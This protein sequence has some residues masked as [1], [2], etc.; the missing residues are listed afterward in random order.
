LWKLTP[1]RQVPSVI[2]V[3]RRNH[4]NVRRTHKRQ[5]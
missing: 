4:Q 3:E 2:D 1:K 5:M